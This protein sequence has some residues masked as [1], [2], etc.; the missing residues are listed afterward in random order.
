MIGAAD[1]RIENHV[2]DAKFQMDGVHFG[3]E[4]IGAP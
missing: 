3:R 4:L 2:I 1:L